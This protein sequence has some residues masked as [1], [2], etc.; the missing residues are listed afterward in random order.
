MNEVT[1]IYAFPSV[2]DGVG[3]GHQIESHHPVSIPGIEGIAIPAGTHGYILKVLQEDTALVRWEVDYIFVLPYLLYAC[4][5]SHLF[6][7]IM[8]CTLMPC[9]FLRL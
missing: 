7:Y 4:T 9:F 8:C 3:Y 6:L 1:T 5:L 2:T